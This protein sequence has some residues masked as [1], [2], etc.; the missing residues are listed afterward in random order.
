MSKSDDALL[1]DA[2]EAFKIAAEA[3]A[4]NRAEALD[5][6]DFAV[7]ERQWPSKIKRQRELDGRPVLTRNLLGPFIRQVVNDGRQ[8]RPAIKVQPADDEADPYT[9]QMITGLIR[10][11]ENYSRADIAYDTALEFAVSAGWGYIKVGTEFATDDGFDRDVMVDAVANPFSIY[12]DPHAQRVDGSDWND[13]FEV[14][15]V[16]QKRF[17]QLYKGA[18][19]VDWDELG[20]GRTDM[21]AW[22]EGS[23]EDR[24][25][26]VANWWRR[27]RAMRNI[28]LLD[29]GEVVPEDEYKA[30]KP[31]FDAAGATVVGARPIPSYRVTVT[32]LTGAEVLEKT[33]PW[34][35]KWIPIV[36]VYGHLININGE[37]VIS[38]LIRSAKDAQR[39]YNFH[40]TTAT[41][42][43]ALAP[44]APFIGPKG[45][46]KTDR[47]KWETA[48][49]QTW[50]Y[51]EYDIVPGMG[52]APARQGFA[53]VPAG[54]IQAA[55]QAAADMR[56]IIGMFEASLGQRSNETSGKA[57]IAR[58][59]E[60]DTST[61]H[62]ID[63]LTRAIRQVGSI[64]LDL[65]PSVY[66]PDRVIR[67]LGPD[68][69]AKT[70][71]LGQQN[72]RMGP[73]GEPQ[74]DPSS[75]EVIMHLYDLSVGKYDIVVTAGPG[76]T[77][78]REE[79]ASQMIE[80]IRA[81]PN[82][83][84]LIGD[85]LAKN[86]DWP[87]AD[88]IA[89]RLHAML[90]P[91]ATGGPDPQTL[92]LQQNLQSATNELQALK[93]NI[94]VMQADRSLKSEEVKI[95]GKKVAI[96]A[97]EAET[98]R[99]AAL[100]GKD[101]VGL[102]KEDVQQTVLATINQLMN[103]P[104]LLSGG[105]TVTPAAPIQAPPVEPAADEAPPP[106]PEPEA[107]ALPEGGP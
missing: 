90:P 34:A 77:T 99:F 7:R 15:Q 62:Y 102:T 94:E 30:N 32:K 70:V 105:P 37:K 80:L 8:N 84:P 11:I 3:E 17:Q 64:V 47:A 33:K 106:S 24:R 104:D 61:F 50:P 42:L 96:A 83:A 6:L 10:Q 88:E 82:A 58:Q 57:I 45:A 43:V 52:A 12:G 28:V 55:T 23:G 9:A 85:L 63:N 69:S 78:K 36:P 95:D 53:G 5:D 29:N 93:R 101:G 54:E 86:L 100:I 98:K 16:P 79:A 22:V 97:Y 38:S 46:F 49:S 1:Q 60:G 39:S 71:T 76:Y 35:G 26:L 92:Q 40:H 20:Y 13:A 89:A 19:K 2:K 81:Y 4:E 41:E 18:D 27:E 87:G 25:I 14:E 44:K 21:D 48:N 56:A 51:I 59:R 103:D 73:N 67:V 31:L 68:S 107:A 74:R 75:G 66:K 65:I 91:Q 72:P